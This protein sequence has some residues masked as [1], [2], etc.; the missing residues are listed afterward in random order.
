MKVERKRLL[1]RVCLKCADFVRQLS[2]HRAF[3]IFQGKLKQNFWIYINN[4][5][6]DMAV[7]DWCHLFGNHSDDLHW[8]R[9]IKDKDA[10]RKGLF[11][12][13][14]ISE[15]TWN[16]YWDN[17]RSYRD[18]NV[19]HIE[20]LPLSNIPDMTFALDSVAFYYD[21]V[22]KELNTPKYPE[23]LVLYYETCLSQTKE[24]LEISFRA[25]KDLDEK[26]F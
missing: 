20:V 10:F 22:R 7:L 4:N 12:N 5:A 11:E 13:L 2:L 26:V 3:D 17:L 6:I 8:K 9:V 16:S 18:K 15:T 24:Y 14:E 21:V 19:G 23:D 1:N 25:T